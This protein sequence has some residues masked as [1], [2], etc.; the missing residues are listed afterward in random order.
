MSSS[1]NFPR[2]TTEADDLDN[3]Y[4][5]YRVDR[6]VVLD[7]ACTNKTAETVRDGYYGAYTGGPGGAW[8]IAYPASPE[9]FGI[10]SPSW[11]RLGRRVLLLVLASFVSSFW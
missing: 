10:L 2:P 9:F 1:F 3:L 4:K 5:A 8:V 6:A 11:L 7:L